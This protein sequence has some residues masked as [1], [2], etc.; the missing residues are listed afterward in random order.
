MSFFKNGIMERSDFF[1]QKLQSR[2]AHF[3]E[4]K[5]I[6]FGNFDYKVQ[7]CHFR[8]KHVFRL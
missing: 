3:S 1:R 6:E 2:I 7:H 5:K 4:N 8:C